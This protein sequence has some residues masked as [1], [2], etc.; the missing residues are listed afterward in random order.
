LH[1]TH[2]ARNRQ[3]HDFRRDVAKQLRDRLIGDFA[4]F[5]VLAENFIP[6]LNRLYRFQPL[7]RMDKRSGDKAI[8]PAAASTRTAI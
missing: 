5:L 1:Q 8:W 6:N 4:G 7:R 2:L 3:R